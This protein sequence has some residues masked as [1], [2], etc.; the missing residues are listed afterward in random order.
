[1]SKLKIKTMVI[2]FNSCG[3]VHNKFVPSGITA[4]QNYLEV[5]GH[6]RKRVMC[7]QM[8]FADDWILQAYHN[9]PAHTAWSVHEFLEK[10]CI[11]LFPQT[12]ILQ[13]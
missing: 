12:L 2:F 1:M 6:P 13:I 4:N 3:V 8:E 11:P 9:A 10:K 7:V 5:L